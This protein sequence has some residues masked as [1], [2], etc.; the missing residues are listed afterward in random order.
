MS[1]AG[2]AI[3]AYLIKQQIQK[4]INLQRSQ[5]SALDDKGKIA[6]QIYV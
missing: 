4:K 1:K 2:A 3:S 6:D 5:N